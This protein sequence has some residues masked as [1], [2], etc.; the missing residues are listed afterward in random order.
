MSDDYDPIPFPEYCRPKPLSDTIITCEATQYY[1]YGIKLAD[2][3]DYFR[4]MLEDSPAT[5]KSG[6]KTYNWLSLPFDKTIVNLFIYCLDKGKNPVEIAGKLSFGSLSNIPIVFELALFYDTFDIKYRNCAFHRYLLRET[7]ISAEYFTKFMSVKT[8]KSEKQQYLSLISAKM[9]EN[10]EL[11]IHLPQDSFIEILS[12]VNAGETPPLLPDISLIDSICSKYPEKISLISKLIGFHIS[13][14][15]SEK[16]DEIS[17]ES[18]PPGYCMIL[19]DKYRV[20][21][22]FDAILIK[23]IDIL[24][25]SL[26]SE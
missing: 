4:Q 5:R 25:K 13:Y 19:R 10:P 18:S 21:N 6:E 20:E 14:Y 23:Y 24:E 3:S 7:D 8:I 15:L 12:G 22:S 17:P 26:F 11:F 2:I 1:F 16:A 9:E